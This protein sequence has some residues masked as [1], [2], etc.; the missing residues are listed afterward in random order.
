MITVIIAV[1]IAYLL[2]SLQIATIVCK[3]IGVSDPRQEGSKNP[4][5]TNVLR[6]GGK[7]PALLVLIG[8]MLKGVIPVLLAQRLGLAGIA[9]GFVALAA[10]L[11]HVFPI[12]FNFKGGKGVATTFGV[13]LALSPVVGALSIA[14][15]L[16]IA[17][18]FRYSSL[19]AIVTC[20]FIP[21]YIA[22]FSDHG[23]LIPIILITIILLWKHTENIKRLLHKEEGKIKL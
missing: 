17:F 10:F 15:W 14:T 16:I 5:T 23:Y 6:L 9:L 1:A 19:A 2:G 8:D 22:I 11:G 7:I 4:G 20:V 18:I 12:F 3:A 21:I 13:S